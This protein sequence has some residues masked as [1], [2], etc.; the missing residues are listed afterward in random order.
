MLISLVAVHMHCEIP[1]DVSLCDT[2]T[3]SDLVCTV[4]S[5]W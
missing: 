4:Y 1:C 2:V 3:N 5:A